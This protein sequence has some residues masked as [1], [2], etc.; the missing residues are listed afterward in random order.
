MIKGGINMGKRL[1]D[2]MELEIINVFDGRKYGYIGDCDIC[3]SRGTGEMKSII[4][5]KEKSSIISIRSN[6][7]IEIPWNRRMKVCEK[8]LIFDFK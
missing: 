7:I 8:T 5:E 3:F 6:D 2:I 4:A 1:S